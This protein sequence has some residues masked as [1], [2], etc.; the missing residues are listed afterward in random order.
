MRGI[1][2]NTKRKTVRV[3]SCGRHGEQTYFPLSEYGTWELAIA[4]AMVFQDSLPE[5]IRFRRYDPRQGLSEQS[6][7]GIV[8][9]RKLKNKRREWVGYRAFWQEGAPGRHRHRTKSFS[10]HTYGG[11]A[12]QAAQN[13]RNTMVRE[14][15]PWLFKDS[16]PE[17]LK[18]E[19]V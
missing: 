2:F 9:V 19:T 12:W 16:T 14:H 5:A 11:G 15:S 1:S 7:T 17:W 6:E 18:K 3:C 8:G 13:H 4:A 10:F